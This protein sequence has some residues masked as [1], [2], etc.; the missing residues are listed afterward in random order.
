MNFIF[1]KVMEVWT[2]RVPC[3]VNVSLTLHVPH[4]V[5][6]SMNLKKKKNNEIYFLTVWNLNGAYD[7]ILE[8]WL[9]RD[10]FF[11]FY[12]FFIIFYLLSNLT[13][14]RPNFNNDSYSH[15]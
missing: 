3:K 5:H 2:Q 8:T 4:C 12:L 15:V 14:C 11:F 6:T 10:V 9:K 13:L 1:L 7:V